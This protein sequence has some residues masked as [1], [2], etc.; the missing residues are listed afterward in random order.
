MRTE[1][2]H[3]GFLFSTHSCVLNCPMTLIFCP[4]LC[5][6][7]SLLTFLNPRRERCSSGISSVSQCY[8]QLRVKEFYILLNLHILPHIFAI[9]RHEHLRHFVSF[10]TANDVFLMV[11]NWWAP[12]AHPLLLTVW[13]LTSV[14]LVWCF[15]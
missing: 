11:Y 7:S 3:G 15:L 12:V 2:Q 6:R 14:A 5:D 13:M 4:M 10:M 8:R 9:N 1:Y